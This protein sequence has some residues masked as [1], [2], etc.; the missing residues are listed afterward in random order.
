MSSADVWILWQKLNVF[1]V[2]VDIHYLNFSLYY[3]GQIP[4]VPTLLD[5]M[6]QLQQQV[7]TRL[8][9]VFP[10]E[11]Q[12]E[13]CLMDALDSVNQR[14]FDPQKTPAVHTIRACVLFSP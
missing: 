1:S 5:L 3:L 2:Y 13:H 4:A 14:G 9:L 7:T 6:K 10:L 11:V 8:A 12:R